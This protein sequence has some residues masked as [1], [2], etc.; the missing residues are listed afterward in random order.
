MHWIAQL[1]HSLRYDPLE[2][3]GKAATVPAGDHRGSIEG[4]GLSG[5]GRG[6]GQLGALVHS[7]PVGGVLAQAYGGT[8]GEDGL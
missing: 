5:S 7:F 8:Q 6:D 1:H 4:M 3:P 2:V